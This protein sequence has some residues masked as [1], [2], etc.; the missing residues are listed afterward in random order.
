MMTAA[1]SIHALL[2]VGLLVA[3]EPPKTP[4]AK[5]EPK[6]DAKPE[7]APPPADVFE[8][9]TVVKLRELA[10]KPYRIRIWL[11]FQKHPAVG[12]ALDEG[13]KQEIASAAQRYFGAAW[14]LDFGAPIAGA[15]VS[16]VAPLDDMP[17]LAAQAKDFAG[18]DKVVWADVGVDARQNGRPPYVVSVR[19]YDFD[20]ASWGPSVTRAVGEEES[21]P[22][23]VFRL[24][25]RQFRATIAVVGLEREHKMVRVVVKGILRQDPASPFPLLALDAPLKVSRDVL[26][27]GEFVGRSQIPWTYLIFRRLDADRRTGVCQVMSSL[28]YPIDSGLLRKSKVLGIAASNSEKASTEVYFYTLQQ[29]V[30]PGDDVGRRALAG[31]EVVLRVQDQAEP[32]LAGSTDRRGRISLAASAVDRTGENRPRV[33]EVTVR[34]GRIPIANFPLVPGDEARREVRVNHDPLLADVSGKIE[35]LQSEIV[36]TL[37]R[38]AILMK[39]LDST[40]KLYEKAAKK[41][42]DDGEAE[43]KRI[44]TRLEEIA[45]EVNSLPGNKQFQDKLNVIQKEAKEKNEKDYRQKSFGKQVNRLFAGVEKLLKEKQIGVTVNVS[46][47]TTTEGGPPQTEQKKADEK[48]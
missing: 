45:K 21:L 41:D 36:D 1:A 15:P 22:N 10:T 5:T 39:R 31:Y 24:V 33:C 16:P 47:S 43:R 48:R 20:F 14:E 18:I 4:D 3:Q 2:F 29:A 28:L 19:E 8:V 42:D 35:A 23:A 11:T 7:S 27:R 9:P 30:N 26:R 25:Y 34:V 17:N 6:A 37:A 12:P 44:K 13:V 38:Q 46:T 40:K 32:F